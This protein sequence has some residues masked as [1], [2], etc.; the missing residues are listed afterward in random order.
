MQAVAPLRFT[1]TATLVD[2]S[3]AEYVAAEKLILPEVHG[4]GY[5]LDAL[6]ESR[7]VSTGPAVAAATTLLIGDGVPGRGFWRLKQVLAETSEVWFARHDKTGELRVF[8]FA[9]DD[10]ALEALRRE[11]TINRLLRETYP[12]RPEFVFIADWN[13][14]AKPAYLEMPHIAGGN[15]AV[16]LEAQG[17]ARSV[18]LADRLELLVQ[19]ADALRCIVWAAPP[20]WRIGCVP[21]RSAANSGGPSATRRRVWRRRR[22]RWSAAGCGG[23]GPTVLPRRSGLD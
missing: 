10:A 16:W 14:E 21:C 3:V 13:F 1:F 8:K 19:A 18:A 2:D 15:L 11:V 22:P 6:V 20:N 9:M 12:G 23:T 17:G 5:R 7:R 4:V